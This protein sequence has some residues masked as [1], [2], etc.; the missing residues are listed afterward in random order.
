M[1]GHPPLGEIVGT[2]AF[3]AVAGADQQ[4]TRIGNF[5]VRGAVLHVLQLGRQPGHRPCAVLV[6]RALFLAL[7]HDAAGQVGDAYGRVGL[8]DVLAACP[9]GAVGIDSQIGRVDLDGDLLVRL[10]QHRHRTGRGV[11]APLGLG[12]RHAL[13]AVSAGFEF[14]LG[15]HVVAFHA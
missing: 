5:L 7:D 14:Q 4:L 2:D 11:D 13:D 6:L 1:I 12:F 9:G 8:V 3:G 10:R 15:E